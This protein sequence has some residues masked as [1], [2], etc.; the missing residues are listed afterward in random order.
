MCAAAWGG[1]VG[2]LGKPGGFLAWSR[3]GPLLESKTRVRGSSPV[4]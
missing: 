3:L 4:S 2:E 1:D